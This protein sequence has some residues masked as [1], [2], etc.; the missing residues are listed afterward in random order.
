MARKV[1][2]VEV[3]YY[4]TRYVKVQVGTPV[5]VSRRNWGGYD[6]SHA[7][8]GQTL[9]WVIK[10]EGTG[11]R[12]SHWEVYL[13]NSAWYGPDADIMAITEIHFKHQT[14]N[15]AKAER[16]DGSSTMEWAIQDLL[17]ELHRRRALSVTGGWNEEG[18]E[19]E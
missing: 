10:S 13:P 15:W 3:D 19:A 4:N 5:T 2:H 16:V 17:I 9:G 1:R 8:T 14:G 18:R 11:G 7:V 6:I 12:N